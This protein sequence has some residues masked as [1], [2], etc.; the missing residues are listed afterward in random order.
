MLQEVLE[1]IHNYFLKKPNPGKYTISGGT[2]SPLPA[3]KEGQRIW[4]VGSDLNDGVYT[5]RSSGILNDDD[6]QEA[7]LLDETFAGTIGALA[8]PPAVIALSEEISKWVESYQDDVVNSPF[9]SESF[10][11][12]SY[13]LKGTGNSASGGDGGPISW[14]TIYGKQLERWRRPCP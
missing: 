14:R 4:I 12:Y 2:I 8:V 3:F 13:T 1:Y 11:G 5:Y 10:N 6:N 7:G 9:A